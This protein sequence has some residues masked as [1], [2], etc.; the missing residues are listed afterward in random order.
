MKCSANAL[1]KAIPLDTIEP[2]KVHKRHV[3]GDPVLRYFIY[4]PK[5]HGICS[6]QFISVHGISR[7]ARE[8]A[9]LYAPLAEQYGVILVVPIFSK[10]HFGG[11]QRL[12]REGGGRRADHALQLITDEVEYLTGADSGKIFLTGFS[13]GGQFAHRYTMAHPDRVR[14]LAI[15][16]AG[17]Y[18]HPDESRR[19]PYGIAST[20]RL[21]GIDFDLQKFL[22]VPT[23]VFVGQ[24]DIV[25]DSGLNQSARIRRQ[26]GLTRLER[27]RYW[28]D[29]MNR[30]AMEYAMDASCEFA[31]IPSVG[32]DF[33]R[34]MRNGQLGQRVFS[35]LFGAPTG[36]PE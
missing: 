9:E 26:Q 36:R 15:A 30:A 31:I 12:G 25:C 18:T 23:S 28:V 32:H 29:A 35:C 8:H 14:R 17:W 16:A 1:A 3:S 4:I 22:Q 5:D 10:R 19:F 6:A 21:K 7:N 27:G 2:G 11:Y 24:W 34:A 13:G 33:S 20:P